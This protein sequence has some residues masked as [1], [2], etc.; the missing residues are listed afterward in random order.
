[1]GRGAF[2]AQFFKNSKFRLTVPKTTAV[3]QTQSRVFF[4]TY[5]HTS[6]TYYYEAKQLDSFGFDGACSGPPSLA[7]RGVGGGGGPRI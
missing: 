2:S 7:R 6:F 3:L 1:M 4:I 5:H